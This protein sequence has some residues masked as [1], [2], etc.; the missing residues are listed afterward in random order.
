MAGQTFNILYGTTV[1]SGQHS[2]IGRYDPPTEI[3]DNRTPR[4][5]NKFPW[6]PLPWRR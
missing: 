1:M 4:G 3:A 5:Q 6:C 2:L